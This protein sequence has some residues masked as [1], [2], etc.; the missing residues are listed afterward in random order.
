LRYYAWAFLTEM[1]KK[2]GQEDF[3]QHE[4]KFKIKVRKTQI[5]RA[6][7]VVNKITY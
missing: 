6:K 5:L 4:N 3:S 2:H 7:L 1:K